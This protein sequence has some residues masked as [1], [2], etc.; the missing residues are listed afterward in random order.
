MKL[1]WSAGAGTTSARARTASRP[2][3]T[4]AASLPVAAMIVTIMK[5]M[6]RT[7]MSPLPRKN[8]EAGRA[9]VA[10]GFSW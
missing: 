9:V 7:S 3:D 8:A 5:S 1:R 6:L 10:R 4:P 2:A